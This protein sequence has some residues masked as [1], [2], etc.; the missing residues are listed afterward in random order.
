MPDKNTEIEIPISTEEHVISARGEV[1]NFIAE[2]L[3]FS[4]LE[5]MHVLTA[6]SELARNIHNYA[7]SGKLQVSLANSPSGKRGLKLVFQDNGP[8]IRDI[9]EAMKER[10]V[11]QYQKG[12]GV[13]L[14]GSKK[15]ADEFHIVS[16]LDQGTLIT[17]IKWERQPS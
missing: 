12:M 4:P 14:S 2:H 17:W 1:R 10:P 5:R 16:V 7:G 13:G 9:D 15:L 3:N 8:G 6:V 11:H